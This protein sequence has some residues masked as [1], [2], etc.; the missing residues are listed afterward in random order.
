MARISLPRSLA[1]A[2]LALLLATQAGAARAAE[3]PTFPYVHWWGNM[4]HENVRA[5]V[6]QQYGGDWRPITQALSTELS[7]MLALRS[8]GMS[9]Q[10]PN[11]TR[12]LSGGQ[13]DV[14][15]DHTRLALSILHCLKGQEAKDAQRTSYVV[16]VPGPGGRS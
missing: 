4:T 6:K 12:K 8:Q 13:L 15:L 14:Y 16:V 9:Y 5:A 11:T 7:K 1:A 2:A 10:V 3:C